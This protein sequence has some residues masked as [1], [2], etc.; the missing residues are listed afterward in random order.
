MFTDPVSGG[1]TIASGIINLFG[2]GK[3]VDS[4]KPIASQL[5][6]MASAGNLTAFGVIVARST[7]VT[8]GFADLYAPIVAR[9]QA[10]HPDWYT[11]AVNLTRNPPAGHALWDFPQNQIIPWVNAHPVAAPGVKTIAGTTTPAAPM[12]EAGIGGALSG[13]VDG[14]LNAIGLGPARQDQLAA[15]AGAS[16]GQAAAQQATKT[17][18]TVGLVVVVVFLLVRLMPK[19]GS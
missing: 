8:Q 1:L 19:R 18:V 15:T 17:V 10:A 2:G 16:A 3:A 4:E 6:S 13:L 12:V 14:F 11:A 9:L 7:I 5:E